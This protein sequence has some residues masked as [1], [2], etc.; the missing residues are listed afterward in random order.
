MPVPASLG[1]ALHS[2][3]V[4]TAHGELFQCGQYHSALTAERG[5]LTRVEGVG[6]VRAA[7]CCR[8]NAA[9]VT[10]GGGVLATRDGVWEAPARHLHGVTQAACGDGH[11]AAVTADGGLYLWGDGAAGQLGMGVARYDADGEVDPEVYDDQLTELNWQARPAQLPRESLGML[12]VHM[13]ACG[14]RHTLVLTEG[15]CVFTFGSGR[16]GQLGHGRKRDAAR[17]MLIEMHGDD[18]VKASG[19]KDAAEALDT[20]QHAPRFQAMETTDMPPSSQALNT[21]DIPPIFQTP[22][23]T[24]QISDKIPTDTAPKHSQH[25]AGIFR[26]AFVAA[27][28]D[29]SMAVTSTGSLYAWGSNRHRQLGLAGKSHA[30]PVLVAIGKNKPVGLAAV[31]TSSAHTLAV[32]TTGTVYACG[33][34]QHGQ[35]GLGDTQDRRRFKRIRP[36]APGKIAEAAAGPSTSAAVTEN[37]ELWTW[38]RGAHGCLGHGGEGDAVAPARVVAMSVD[39]P[40]QAV[41]AGSLPVYMQ[42]AWPPENDATRQSRPGVAVPML[43]PGRRDADRTAVDPA[44]LGRWHAAVEPED[45]ATRQSRPGVAVPMLPPGRRGSHRDADRSAVDPAGLGRWHAAVEPEARWFS[46]V[47]PGTAGEARRA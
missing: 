13:V 33:S 32:S 47:A 40:L 28:G 37:G 1:L 46:P 3:Y 39:Y 9:F 35:L 2:S 15:G 17:P 8:D 4:V 16:H 23:D 21:T 19:E 42:R 25:P 30:A 45:D 34:N 11:Y 24:A 29:H 5:I 26:V 41:G 12:A 38:G 44:G 22:D 14:D 6:P 43:P 20:M 27:G 31:A 7:A 10:A 36:F 18:A